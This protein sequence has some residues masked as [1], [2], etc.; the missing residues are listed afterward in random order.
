MFLFCLFVCLFVCFNRI[1]SREAQLE[2]RQLEEQNPL[3]LAEQFRLMLF[4]LE[5]ELAEDPQIN[6]KQQ[7]PHVKGHAIEEMLLTCYQRYC[8]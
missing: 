8:K 6:S 1:S 7:F 4:F 3:T 5:E 2:A